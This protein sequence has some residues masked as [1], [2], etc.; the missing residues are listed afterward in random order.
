MYDVQYVRDTWVVAAR[1][2]YLLSQRDF[3]YACLYQL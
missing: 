2:G 1:S 3:G